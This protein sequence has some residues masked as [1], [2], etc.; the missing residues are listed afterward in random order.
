MSEMTLQESFERFQCTGKAADRCR[1][2]SNVYRQ[3]NCGETAAIFAGLA[4]ALDEIL[5]KGTKLKHAKA[6]NQTDKLAGLD[7][8][9]KM[10]AAVQEGK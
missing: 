6:L 8:A 5:A 3:K 9:M 4:R 7:R 1:M 2:L 10:N